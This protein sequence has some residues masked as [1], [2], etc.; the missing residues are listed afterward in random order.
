MCD[1]P[2]TLANQNDIVD[3]TVFNYGKK[4]FEKMVRDCQRTPMQWTSHA[5]HAGFTSSTVKPFLPLSDTWPELN[6]EQQ[7]K[8]ACSHL[9]LFQQLVKLRQQFPFY[10]G[11]QKKVIATKECYAFLRWLGTDA[12]LITINVNKKGVDAIR[13]DFNQL[14]ECPDKELIGEVIAKSCNVPTDSFIGKEGNH[15]PLNNL[16]L[17]SNEAVVFKLLTHF[18]SNKPLIQ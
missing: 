1:R 18:V 11:Y 17:Q 5:A 3:I 4:H 8:A 7:Q 16:I 2:F 6:V 12:Y 9:K 10:G 13:M 14:L 15:V